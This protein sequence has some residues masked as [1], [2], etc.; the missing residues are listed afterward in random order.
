MDWEQEPRSGTMDSWLREHDRLLT[1]I[2]N[3]VPALVS[4][5]DRD[6][7]YLL[8]NDEYKRWF[9]IPPARVIGRTLSEIVGEAAYERI[10][11]KV[12]AVLAGVRVQFEDLLHYADGRSRWVQASYAPDFAPD[13]S[14]R[15]FV[16]Y[17][18]DVTDRKR[19]ELETDHERRR[20]LHVVSQLPGMVCMTSGLDHEI[21]LL[22]PAA[23]EMLGNRAELIGKR[24]RDAPRELG[25]M[26]SVEAAT[27][28]FETGETLHFEDLCVTSDWSR[29]GVREERFFS[30]VVQ[31]LRSVDGSVLGVIAFA[32]EV[33]DQVKARRELEASRKQAA[34]LAEAS[35][36]FSSSLDLD[37]TLASVA[38]LSL[39][40][41]ADICL[42]YLKE[43]EETLRVAAA[44]TDSEREE[45]LARTAEGR[46][47]LSSDVPPARVTRA[48]RAEWEARVSP[49]WLSPHLLPSAADGERNEALEQ[50]APCSFIVAPLSLP[51]G[52]LGS[53]AYGR[54]AGSRAY[55]ESDLLFG[56]ELARRAALAVDNARSYLR[57][58]EASRLKDEFLATVSHE[59]RTPLSAILGWATILHAQRG[60]KQDSLLRGLEVI[61]RNA[62][63]QAR[64]IEDIL[65]VSRI[66]RGQLHLRCE[67]VDLSEI[68]RTAI[69]SFRA[70]GQLLAEE[71]IGLGVGPA[72]GCPAVGDRAEHARGQRERR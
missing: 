50:L 26:T 48:N 32:H 45:L 47:P 42:I 14:V 11:P 71:K 39:R 69:D 10:G 7:R 67:S 15:G 38:R 1:S 16:E 44:A 68:A 28:V 6:C 30:S 13:G 9:G 23:R 57:A 36:L 53:I 43:G 52:V 63:S 49:S 17:V 21:A 31:P 22:S 64:I 56:E 18:L 46:I 70:A 4:Y 54:A 65:D 61:E 51:S 58:E 25:A 72:A 60:R 66:V 2:C 59:L 29:C 24:L 55:T 8:A 5:L 20:L 62:R 34:F 3:A 37:S 27:H 12:E 19:A 35:A 40:E 41:F 33:S